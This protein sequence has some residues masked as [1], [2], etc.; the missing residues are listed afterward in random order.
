MGLFGKKRYA[1]FYDDKGEFLGRAKYKKWDSLIK[2]GKRRYNIIKEKATITKIKGLFF[3]KE[4]THY[5]YNNPNPMLLDKKQEPIYNAEL[6]NIQLDTKVMRDLNNLAKK[7]LAELL[8]PI[9][10]LIGLIVI[11]VIIYLAT[12]H[13][14]TGGTTPTK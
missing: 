10:I 14:I 3:D 8:T 13:S 6:Y 11:G 12:G 5:N 1:L 2:V 7:S 9:N 4:Y